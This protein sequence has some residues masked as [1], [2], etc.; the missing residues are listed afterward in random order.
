MRTVQNNNNNNT[1]IHCDAK[2][3]LV[4]KFLLALE[5]GEM[6]SVDPIGE[7]LHLLHEP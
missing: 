5:L 6:L 3:L 4:V 1:A 2:S 7:G